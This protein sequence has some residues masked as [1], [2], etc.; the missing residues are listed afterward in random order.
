MDCTQYDKNEPNKE[1]GLFDECEKSKNKKINGI[2]YFPALMLILGMIASIY[3]ILSICWFDNSDFSSALKLSIHARLVLLSIILCFIYFICSL[4]AANLF[5]RRK[6]GTRSAM[7]VN[8]IHYRS[9]SF[10]N[11]LPGR[12]YNLYYYLDI[13][14]Y[15]FKKD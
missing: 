10:G 13:L 5:F 12:R 4:Y 2:L 6:K 1:S 3:S 8:A 7:I 11:R 14:L 15:L 9:Y